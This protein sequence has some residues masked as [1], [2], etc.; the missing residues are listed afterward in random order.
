MCCFNIYYSAVLSLYYTT[1]SLTDIL[2]ANVTVSNVVPNIAYIV[3]QFV[4]ITGDDVRST[5]FTIRVPPV[6]SGSFD[7]VNTTVAYDTIT[8][9]YLPSANSAYST[10]MVVV[11]YIVIVVVVTFL[12]IIA[13]DVDDCGSW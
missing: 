4:N 13:F 7:Y 11:H 5:V 12:V 6:V 2:V 10:G 3:T 1:S 8:T 9:N